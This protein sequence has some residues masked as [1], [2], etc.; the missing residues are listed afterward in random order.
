[1]SGQLLSDVSYLL[2]ISCGF[3]FLLLVT[4]GIMSLLYRYIPSFR[5]WVDNFCENISGN[6]WEDEEED[7]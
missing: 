2:F 5:R 7:Y 3:I 4:D 6:A 1:M